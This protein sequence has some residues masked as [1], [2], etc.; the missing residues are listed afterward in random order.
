MEEVLEYAGNDGP[1]T[2][3]V[4]KSTDTDLDAMEKLIE[5]L[6]DSTE[7]VEVLNTEV[8]EEL[9]DKRIKDKD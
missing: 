6:T 4:H 2:S 8:A 5:K 7:E 1:D 3:D 9:R